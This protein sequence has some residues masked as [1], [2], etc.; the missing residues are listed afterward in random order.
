MMK[1]IAPLLL[2]PL[3]LPPLDVSST[4]KRKKM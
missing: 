1:K 2:L 3:L 4:M